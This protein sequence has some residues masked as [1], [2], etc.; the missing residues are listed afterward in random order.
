MNEYVD[1]EQDEEMRKAMEAS[2]ESHIHHQQAQRQHELEEQ[3]ALEQYLAAEGK[4]RQEEAAAAALVAASE[5]QDQQIS[6]AIHE[7]YDSVKRQ[8][9]IQEMNNYLTSYTVERSETK[10]VGSWDCPSCT[11]VND[12]YV[13]NCKACGAKAPLH[14]LTFKKFP[15]EL[16]FG[17]EVEIIVPNGKRDGFTYES[18]AKSLSEF[19]DKVEY[20]GY[21]HETS[22][23]WKIVTDSSLRSN[24]DNDLCFELVSPILV[25]EGDTGL[26]RFRNIMDAIARIGISTNASCGFHVHIDAESSSLKNLKAICNCFVSLENAFD[27]LVASKH[28]HASNRRTNQN[29]YIQSNRL[30]FRQLSNRQRWSSI[31]EVR[32]RYELVELMNPESRYYKLNLTN[33][34]KRNRPSTIEFRQFGGIDDLPEAEI[35][36]RFLAAFCEN[37]K[38]RNIEG[39][40]LSEEST[41]LDE[42]RSLFNLID[43]TGLESWYTV[44][45]QLFNGHSIKNEWMCKICYR[46]FANSRSLSQHCSALGHNR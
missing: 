13:G 46:K 40:L 23:H 14:V 32:N 37:A 3:L 45:R 43:D 8:K 4:K 1:D 27:L 12:P 36:V 34:T 20:R 29:K 31:A 44:D 26:Q 6:I 5:M 28:S 17:L 35:W 22:A 18:I 10:A 41:V 25:G 33:L 11:L 42:L 19:G 7:S 15:N 39:C 2:L 24:H 16:R 38:R 30:A 9:T 21:T